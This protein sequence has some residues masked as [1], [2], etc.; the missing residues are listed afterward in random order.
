MIEKAI[1]GWQEKSFT[2]I[3]VDLTDEDRDLQRS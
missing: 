1:K 3:K 2:C